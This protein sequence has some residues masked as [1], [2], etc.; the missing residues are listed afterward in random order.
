MNSKPLSLLLLCNPDPDMLTTTVRES[1][2]PDIPCR[3]TD[4]I[5]GAGEL[6]KTLSPDLLLAIFPSHALKSSRDIEQIRSVYPHLPLLVIG[7]SDAAEQ[8]VAMMKAGASDYI[9]VKLLQKDAITGTAPANLNR[10]FFQERGIRIPDETTLNS[11][12]AKS[13]PVEGATGFPDLSPGLNPQELLFETMFQNHDAM[14]FLVDPKT[15]I[16]IKANR[17]ASEF[18]GYDFSSG[19]SIFS[20]NSLSEE[21]VKEE[22][23]KAYRAESNYFQFTHRIAS[24][25]LRSVDVHSTPLHINGRE[26]LFS[27][28]RDISAKKEAEESLMTTS[29]RLSTL[30]E[31]LQQGILFEDSD[32]NI[33]LLNPVF[34]RLFGLDP[35]PKSYIGMKADDVLSRCAA[36]T[37]DPPAF[38]KEIRRMHKTQS[39]SSKAE[40]E[41]SNGIIL[42]LVHTHISRQDQLSGH[43][44]KFRN[45]SDIRK[46][47]DA[48]RW[49]ESLLRFMANSSPLAFFVV[50]NRTDA[51]LYHNHRFCEIWGITHL[52]EKIRAGVLK[53]ND[54]IPDCLPVLA[55]IP[56]FAESC[57]PLQDENNRITIED[58]IPFNDGRTIRRFSTQIRGDDDEYYGRLYIFEDITYRV[59]AEAML[60]LQRDLGIKLSATA[61][62]NETLEQSM[63]ILMLTE[64]VS[65]GGIYLLNPRTGNL[66]LKVHRNLPEGFASRTSLFPEDSEQVQIVLKGKPT[67]SLYEELY[68]AKQAPPVSPEIGYLA[69]LPIQSEGKV[70][71]S[72]NL[73]TFQR[74]EFSAGVRHTLEAFANQIGIA[75][76]RI[77][78]E[79]A[80]K[81]SQQNFQQMFDTLDDFMFILDGN[82]NIIK[83]N[84]VVEKRLGYT[85]EELR[86]QHVLSVHPPERREEAGR[87]VADMLAGK[88]LFCP[89]PLCRKDG[90]PIPVE[91]RVVMGMWDNEPALYGISRDISE[92]QKAERELQLRESY[93]SAVITNHPGRFWLKDTEGRFI[94]V[95]E[96]NQQFL[97]SLNENDQSIIGKTDFDFISSELSA[98]YRDEDQMVI[99]TRTSIVKEE[100][101]REANQDIWR[102]KFKFPVIGKNGEVIGVSGYS[103]DITERKRSEATLRMQNAAFESFAL[104]MMITDAAGIIQWVNPAFCRLTGYET[105][106]VIGQNPSFLKSGV[107]KEEFYTELY[108]VLHTGKVWSS[109][110]IN[111]RKDGTLYPEEQTITPVFDENGVATNFIAIKID[112][113]HRKEI[114]AA[115]HLSEERWKVALEGSGDGIWD[116]NA[117]TG[118]VFYSIQWKA[119]LG[120]ENH[121]IGNTLDEWNSRIHPDDR[122]QSLTELNRHFT[123][124]SGIYSAEYRMRCKDG[125]WK[126]ILN[127]GKTIEWTKNRKPGRVIGT[128]TDIT[129]RKELEEALRKGIEHEKELND[130]KSR[131]VSNAS[132]EFRTPL[133]SILIISES[134]IAYWKRM[135]DSQ[136]TERLGKIREQILHLT[137]NVNEVL[138]LARIQEGKIDINTE[139]TDMVGL[140]TRV[141][142]DFR[143]SGTNS[144]EL[145]FSHSHPEIILS[146]DVRLIRQILVNLISNALK[147]SPDQ[148]QVRVNTTKD[149][150]GVCLTVSD[151]GI[152]I[153][154]EEQKLIFTPFF[155]A[156]NT[157]FVKGNGLGLNIVHESVHMLGGQISFSSEPGKGTEF[158]VWIPELHPGDVLKTSDHQK[159]NRK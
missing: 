53:N 39:D 20:I 141:I 28:V 11:T 108:Q 75:I 120:F 47:N 134:L 59:K 147:Y 62:L 90:T 33:A 68:A 71:G 155:R 149:G 26:L 60:N 140:C 78:A 50:D 152:G 3:Q 35:D 122:E 92:R 124:E 138:Q 143:S 145:V 100:Y 66:E 106:E 13:E 81:A 103:V 38:M 133:A 139:I 125:S 41:L 97:N 42:E 36:M 123:A 112:I 85:Q 151:R 14:M 114:E 127:R 56:A 126:W 51:I 10:R 94:M 29:Q 148:P 99:S 118:E 43:V 77:L 111:R 113:T 22:I 45:I 32:G 76:A 156:N 9:P 86:N 132:H 19:I 57:A 54:I 129:P 102:E 116:W 48:L 135:E 40:F 15:G 2:D 80:F 98:G 64:L 55:D 4:S 119:M 7:D 31:N 63:N 65:C 153:P 44:W 110:I 159:L 107:Q 117:Q 52:E 88:A 49:N 37:P 146:Q 70:F 25:S 131:F 5:A 142:D 104:A 79:E 46:S 136:I 96:K 69:V 12:K 83:I 105:C 158:R 23:R 67:Y 93:L 115:L 82:G 1:L 18:Y 91:T 128:H 89:V 61:S 27:I 30:V 84:P 137:D 95:N 74:K 24:G 130:L 121:E 87:I 154:L 34:T 8:A 16:V 157:R 73:A 101:V 144:A 21:E 58:Y 109:E 150:D 72:L 17:S 6:T